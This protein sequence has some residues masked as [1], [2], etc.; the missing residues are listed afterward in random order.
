MSGFNEKPKPVQG[1][2]ED[3]LQDFETS[4]KGTPLEHD[5]ATRSMIEAGF[6]S[7][8]GVLQDPKMWK[9]QR[10]AKVLS[11]DSGASALEIKEDQLVQHSRLPEDELRSEQ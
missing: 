1:L 4:T 11:G 7:P 2:S 9:E 5:L 8:N 10:L 3:E 6:V